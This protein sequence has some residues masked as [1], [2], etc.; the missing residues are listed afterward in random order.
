LVTAALAELTREVFPGEA[1]DSVAIERIQLAALLLAQGDL[2][3]LDDAVALGRRDWRDLLVAGG[4]ADEGW[5]E[6]VAAE[7][8]PPPARHI[9]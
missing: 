2:R 3:K 7:L 8:E 6:R 1:R 4:L 9:Y 5:Q